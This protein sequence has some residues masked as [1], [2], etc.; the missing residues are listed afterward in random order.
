MFFKKNSLILII[1]MLSASLTFGIDLSKFNPSFRM[2]HKQVSENKNSVA[3]F[4]QQFAISQHPVT[5]ETTFGVMMRLESAEDAINLKNNGVEIQTVLPSGIV[6]AQLTESNISLISKSKEVLYVELS[7]KAKTK[8]DVSR[9]E[10]RINTVHEG[11]GLDKA[12]KG[13]GVI[14]GVI[15]SG[16]DIKHGN[17]KN[18]DGTT[19]ILNL[20]D[21]TEDGAAPQPYTYGTEWTAQQINTGICTQVAPDDHGTH[22]AGTAAGN[23]L[24]PANNLKY[25]GIAPKSDIIFVKMTGDD[26]QL[27]D[28]VSYIFSK[29]QL[30]GKPA[31]INMSLGGHSGA[32]DGSSLSDQAY[33]ELIGNGKIIVAAAGNEGEY[34]I[35]ASASVDYNG[36]T[37]VF[38]TNPDNDQ[39]MFEAWYDSTY[40]MDVKLIQLNPDLSQIIQQTDWISPGA[41]IDT[42]FTSGQSILIDT[43]ETVNPENHAR[44]IVF[45]IA[46]ENITSYLWGLGFRA[47][48]NGQTAEFDCWVQN[49]NS[50]NF[51]T[52][53]PN[54]IPGDFFM[55]VGSP[56]V[57][58]EVITVGAYNTKN[59]WIDIAGVTHN[60]EFVVGDKASFSSFGPTR[61]G[62]IKPEICAPGNLICSTLTSDLPD[63][64]EARVV[65]GGLYHVLEGTSM[66]TPHIT[67]IVALMLQAR[68]YLNNEEV[69]TLI[70][71]NSRQ[72]EFVNAYNSIFGE[73]P[74]IAWGIGKVDGFESVFSATTG[75]ED[76]G[77]QPISSQLEQNYPNPFNPETNISYSI[78]EKSDVE[79]TVFNMKG[80]A[81]ATLVKKTQDKGNYTMNFNAV[82]LNSGLYFYKLKI[83]DKFVA[84]KKMLLIK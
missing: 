24:S 45:G 52:D 54:T 79:L 27:V 14:V 83:N 82:D 80:A 59:Q 42:T 37:V 53:I 13:E 10:T 6:S 5:N 25:I 23:G 43:K 61:D 69:L 26:N 76:N 38:E 46:G 72:D 44:H 32:H 3:L 1:L 66:A 19:R 51:R 17:F 57:V 75:I 65:Q 8:M 68:P 29:A 9:V 40:S 71:Q 70:A 47:H 56:G 62:R 67:G 20:W 73:V 60:E 63:P 4:S 36:G 48:V 84:T 31:V 35:H 74:N 12:Y 77:L 39:I 78:N 33:S 41:E 18:E 11:T 30:L 22:V 16:I 50:G 2:V 7:S 15:D 34:T 81:V 64:S 49:E 55:T 21:Q 28:A 58:D